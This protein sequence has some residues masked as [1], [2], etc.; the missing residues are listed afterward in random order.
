LTNALETLLKDVIDPSIE[1]I[2]QDSKLTDKHTVESIN[3]LFT[4][5]QLDIMDWLFEGVKK[6][7]EEK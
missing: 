2:M 3:D 6:D 5:I 1:S 7:D 4:K